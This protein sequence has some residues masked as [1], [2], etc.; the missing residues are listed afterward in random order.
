[1]KG[2]N[3]R[4]DS[5]A[6]VTNLSH[7]SPLYTTA[8]GSHFSFSKMRLLLVCALL[9]VLV[10]SYGFMRPTRLYKWHKALEGNYAS[11]ENR[12]TEDEG[13][14]IEDGDSR[15]EVIDLSD[16]VDDVDRT[17][18]RYVDED[19][20]DEVKTTEKSVTVEEEN[21]AEE[22]DTTTTTKTTVED[23]E[24]A[25]SETTTKRSSTESLANSLNG[26][27]SLL[28]FHGT[29]LRARNSDRDA[30]RVDLAWK[31]NVCERWNIAE[32]D[33]KVRFVA[34]TRA[35]ATDIISCTKMGFI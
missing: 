3:G 30:V 1:M 20:D 9:S 28:S 8:S 34:T 17:A 21:S 29:F 13:T 10:P 23:D 27:R 14:S 25:S 6:E 7:N 35:L 18:P 15:G 4:H 11:A 16:D 24:D 2:R 22:D 19:N 26:P 33:G 32:V 12:V 31:R 5:L